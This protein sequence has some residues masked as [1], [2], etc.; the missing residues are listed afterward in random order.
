MSEE[1]TVT[2]IFGKDQVD[3]FENNG[4]FTFEEFGLY[5]KQ[6]SFGSKLELD[7]FILGLEAGEGWQELSVFENK[8]EIALL[9]QEK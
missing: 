9:E 1:N 4:P 2:V 7:A 5:V 3:K 6:F 8:L